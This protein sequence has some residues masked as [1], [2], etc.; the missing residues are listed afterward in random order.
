MTCVAGAVDASGGS[1]APSQQ[2]GG[3]GTGPC[4]AMSLV[5]PL[6]CTKPGQTWGECGWGGDGS[7]SSEGVL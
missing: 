5:S 3:S 6:T 4:T 2:E 7:S 1:K